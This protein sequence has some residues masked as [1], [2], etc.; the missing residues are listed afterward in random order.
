MRR[1]AYIYNFNFQATYDVP[2]SIFEQCSLGK[3][4]EGNLKNEFLIIQFIELLPINKASNENWYQFSFL[5]VLMLENQIL[6]ARETFFC[7]REIS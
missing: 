4:R 7:H 6:A 5:I 1:Y 3:K 2:T